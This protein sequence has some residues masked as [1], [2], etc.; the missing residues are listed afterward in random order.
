M[1]QRRKKVCIYDVIVFYSTYIGST[2]TA[3][4]V[5]C[6]ELLVFCVSVLVCVCV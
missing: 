1:F 4:K 3:Q 6:E 5:C 2:D